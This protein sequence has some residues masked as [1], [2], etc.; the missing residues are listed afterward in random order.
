MKKKVQEV[1][2]G[3]IFQ[4]K[5]ELSY[6]TLGKRYEV[7]SV[8]YDNGTGKQVVEFVDDSK[9][10]HEITENFLERH[11]KLSEIQ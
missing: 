8:S 9:H 3:Q 5:K 4:V 1:K 2:K 6:F 7:E 10:F 11:F